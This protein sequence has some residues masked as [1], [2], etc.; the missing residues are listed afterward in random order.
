MPPT[1][2]LSVNFYVSMLQEFLQKKK[3]K[4]DKNVIFS[5]KR[6]ISDFEFQYFW[7]IL[8]YSVMKRDE[9]MG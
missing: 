3:E 5:Y 4:E 1:I 7:T 2:P 9:I 6:N 8:K